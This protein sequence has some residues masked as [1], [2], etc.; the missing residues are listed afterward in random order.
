MAFVD[1]TKL[2][3]IWNM[4]REELGK[5]SELERTKS[6]SWRLREER[7]FISYK[8]TYTKSSQSLWVFSTGL[9]VPKPSLCVWA[10]GILV[11]LFLWHAVGM[12]KLCLCYAPQLCLFCSVLLCVL[13][14]KA[15][16][17]NHDVQM[18]GSILEKTAPVKWIA[19]GNKHLALSAHCLNCI[20]QWQLHKLSNAKKINKQLVLLG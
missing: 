12:N 9:K 1:Y 15:R 6:W 16:F 13:R 19:A 7:L 2:C 17:V 10:L 8:V 3:W 5:E 4:E 18:G 14:E 11:E 20:W